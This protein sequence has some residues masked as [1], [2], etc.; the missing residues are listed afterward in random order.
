MAENDLYEWNLA[1]KDTSNGLVKSGTINVV[2]P[3][4]ACPEI[5]EFQITVTVSWS[6]GR[7]DNKDDTVDDDLTFQTIFQIPRPC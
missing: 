2:S 4:L 6:E 7:D 3:V 5:D 1:L